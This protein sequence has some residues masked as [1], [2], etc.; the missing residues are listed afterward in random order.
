MFGAIRVHCFVG[1]ADGKAVFGA[2]R[3]GRLAQRQIGAIQ[4]P[5][6]GGLGLAAGVLASYLN[7]LVSFGVVRVSGR[8]VE[9]NWI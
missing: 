7:V 3:P 4:L 1:F 6:D 5:F 8:L 2:S 9:V